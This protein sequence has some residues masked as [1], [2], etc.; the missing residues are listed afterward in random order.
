M[1]I[2]NGTCFT[3]L[4]QETVN[5]VYLVMEVKNVNVIGKLPIFSNECVRKIKTYLFFLSS[6]E[7]FPTSKNTYLFDEKTFSLI[8][9]NSLAI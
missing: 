7:S 6:Y 2:I 9:T 8:L 1:K 4:L 3:L 5:H